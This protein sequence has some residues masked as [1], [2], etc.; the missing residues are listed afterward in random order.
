MPKRELI[1]LDTDIG[2]DIDDAVALAYLLAQ[3]RCELLGITT[4]TGEAQK[5]AMLADAICRRA[6]RTDI[7]IHSG[8][9]RAMLIEKRQ[10]VA[11]QAE[12]LPRWEH[13]EDFEPNTAVQFLRET[14]RS[15]P[16]EVT[17][18]TIGPLMNVGV[19][20]ALDPEVPA[21]LKRMVMMAGSFFDLQR[22]EFNVLVDPHAA[23]IALAREVPE[24]RLY[25]LNVTFKCQMPADE[26]RERFQGGPLDVVI[27]MAGVWFEKR[28]SIVFHD[29]LAAACIFE[30][31]ICDYRRGRVSVDLAPGDEQGMTCLEEDEAGT[32][33]V[34]SGVAPERFFAHYFGAVGCFREG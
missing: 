26:C 10:P 8:V 2:T 21:M 28:P 13:R 34:A 31:D 32:H 30:P 25:G 6:G 23:A 12:V 9:E 29:P 14:I 18:L 17:L 1:L 4:A 19:L 33:V 7:P 16:G 15:R 27:D 22:P 24:V 5:R 3:P 20:F 11:Q